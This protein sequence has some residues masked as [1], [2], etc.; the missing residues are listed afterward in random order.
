M[1]LFPFVMSLVFAIPTPEEVEKIVSAHE[2]GFAAVKTLRLDYVI[3]VEK[4]GQPPTKM[5]SGKWLKK[6]L[7][8]KF[9][10]ATFINQD[11]KGVIHNVENESMVAFDVDSV[12]ALR[13]RQKKDAFTPLNE[14]LQKTLHAGEEDYSRTKCAIT[15]RDPI[16]TYNPIHRWFRLI[17]GDKPFRKFVESNE[18]SDVSANDNEDILVFVPRQSNDTATTITTLHFDKLRNYIIVRTDH[19]VTDG[20]SEYLNKFEV[21]DFVESNGIWF[22]KRMELSNGSSRTV[23]TAESVELNGEI[24]DDEVSLD[25]PV[26]ARV[27]EPNAGVTHIWGSDRRPKLTMNAKEFADY[28]LE[29]GGRG[30]GSAPQST[31]S[32][33]L[34]IA[35]ILGVAALAIIILYQR[36]AR[37]R[38]DAK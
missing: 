1:H 9:I 2:A 4:Q 35:N 26:G 13:Y 32:S 24:S 10:D 37:R 8:E 25:F 31:R 28:E 20:K 11:G 6:G 16:M 14:V 38:G 33:V 34:V 23:L 36:M 3:V 5:S 19:A 21:T 27:D 30:A 17:V 29:A 12:R 22:P 7:K 18:V 15:P